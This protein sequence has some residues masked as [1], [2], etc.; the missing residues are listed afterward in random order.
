MSN[1]SVAHSKSIVTL[2]CSDDCFDLQCLIDILVLC[3]QPRLCYLC[4]LGEAAAIVVWLLK[5]LCFY[6]P[7]SAPTYVYDHQTLAV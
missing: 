4:I 6:L 2:K 7:S 3:T 1:V 5:Y